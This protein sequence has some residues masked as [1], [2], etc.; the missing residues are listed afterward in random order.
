MLLVY[1]VKRVTAKERDGG[2]CARNESTACVYV[3]GE[4]GG[5]SSSSIATGP[6]NEFARSPGAQEMKR[7]RR[8]C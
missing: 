1:E 5:S 6:L 4:G 3:K 2:S 7:G 8:H